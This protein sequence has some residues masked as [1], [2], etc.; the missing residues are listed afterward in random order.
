MVKDSVELCYID[1]VFGYICMMY[2]IKLVDYG[3]VLE[4]KVECIMGGG[5]V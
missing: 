4:G 3:I 1:L 5:D 2:W